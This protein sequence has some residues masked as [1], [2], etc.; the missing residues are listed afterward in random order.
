[1][2]CLEVEKRSSSIYATSTL[3]EGNLKVW[4]N[5]LVIWFNTFRPT[6]G[7]WYM[8][9]RVTTVGSSNLEIDWGWIQAT[10][11]SGNTGHAG[12]ANKWGVFAFQTHIRLYD[13]TSQAGFKYNGA[14]DLENI[15]QDNN[16]LQL[17]KYQQ[18]IVAGTI[19]VGRTIN[20]IWYCTD[21]SDGNPSLDKMKHLLLQMMKHTD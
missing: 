15:K 4:F 18:D 6:S 8:E 17:L 10:E 21:A 7:K 9:M 19:K 2:L 16:I 13:E 1:M 12:Q 14:L 20:N 3:S 5:H 11:Y